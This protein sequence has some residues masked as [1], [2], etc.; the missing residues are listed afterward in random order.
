MPRFQIGDKVYYIRGNVIAPVTITQIIKNKDAW[1][2]QCKDSKSDFYLRENDLYTINY[3][4]LN[5]DSLVKEEIIQ[6][7]KS[8][9]EFNQNYLD[10]MPSGCHNS[11]GAG[12]ATGCRN[13]AKEVLH[14]VKT[15]EI[16]DD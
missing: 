1:I 4:L 12:E 16:L 11:Y 6:Y 3:D 7:L 9:I 2:Y 15:G 8:I 5:N 10:N 13:T 14:F